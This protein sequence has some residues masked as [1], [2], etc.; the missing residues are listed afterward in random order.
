MPSEIVL[1]E[2]EIRDLRNKINAFLIKN[3][4]C[5]QC[6][7]SAGQFTFGN[8]PVCEPCYDE[9]CRGYNGGGW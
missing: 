3:L 9:I 8:L 2:K 6:Y 1:M 5:S 4:L 7:S